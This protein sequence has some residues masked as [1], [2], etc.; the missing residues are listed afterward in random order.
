MVKRKATISVEHS[1]L[2]IQQNTLIYDYI[3]FIICELCSGGIDEVRK[4]KLKLMFI[5]ELLGIN[6]KIS[7]DKIKFIIEKAKLELRK[8]IKNA[9]EDPLF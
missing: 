5:R 4:K 3:R 1:K 8:A 9:R 6:K 7:N 2:T